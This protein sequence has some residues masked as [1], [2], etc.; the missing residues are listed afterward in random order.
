MSRP[1]SRSAS[2]SGSPARAAPRLAASPGATLASARCSCASP[3]AARALSLKA[4]EVDFMGVMGA[5]RSPDRRA[6]RP[7][8]RPRGGR[9]LL[10]PWRDSL[11]AM[12][13]RQPRSPASSDV[14]ARGRDLLRLALDD[15]VGDVGILDREG[16]AEAA[17]HVR[18]GQLDQLQA[19]DRA[20]A[21]GAAARGCRARAGPSS[22]RG[23]WRGPRA[24]HRRAFTPRTSTRKEMSS[25]TLA[26]NAAARAF[27]AGSAASS[28]G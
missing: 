21:A 10:R 20:Q 23:R 17:A 24:R 18:V 19:L 15:G 6:R 9:Q 14:R 27:H 5:R 8:P 25:C 7:A 3:S 11:P 12:F 16:A 28:A 26:A 1:R 4:G 22:C 2:N 13:I